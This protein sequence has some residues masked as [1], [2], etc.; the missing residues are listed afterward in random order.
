MRRWAAQIFIMLITSSNC[1]DKLKSDWPI[2][3]SL[4]K[5]E[6]HFHQIIFLNTNFPLCS[7][8]WKI[9][10]K[11]TLN[12]ATNTLAY[13]PTSFS[14]KTISSLHHRYHFSNHYYL[15]HSSPSVKVFP[16][17]SLVF[18][19]FSFGILIIFYLSKLKVLHCSF[20]STMIK[21]IK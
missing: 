12:E 7:C 2:L 11:S 15:V 8:K 10:G 13:H 5:L 20:S 6:S 4:Q 17:F 9:L 3:F 21:S 1:F 14:P 18:S 19:W 16:S